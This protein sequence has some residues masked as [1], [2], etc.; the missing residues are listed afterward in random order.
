MILLQETILHTHP[1]WGNAFFYVF[2]VT[3]VTFFIV[4]LSM[5]RFYKKKGAE[6][7]L[8][9]Q[10]HAA[11][12]DVIRKD[13]SEAIEKL[14]LEMLK[15]EE[16]RVRQWMESDKEAIQVLNKVLTIFELSGKVGKV[17]SKKIMDKIDALD[18]KIDKIT[19]KN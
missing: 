14:R 2:V 4:A 10:Q 1:I 19:S 13:H 5:M 9:Q 17:D 15:R 16:E 18:S 6:L 11:R 8:I 7:K 3:A 12:I